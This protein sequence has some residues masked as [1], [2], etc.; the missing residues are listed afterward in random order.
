MLYLYP[1]LLGAAL[2]SAEPHQLQAV[3]EEM[4]VPHRL[5]LT[6]ELLK[7]ELAVIMLQ[8]KL[9]KEAS[10]YKFIVLIARKSQCTT[11][12]YLNTFQKQPLYLALLQILE[13][14]K[15]NV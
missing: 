15:N 11:V 14:F 4:N 1:F 6:L 12:Y 5:A 9:G 3:L 7:K 10:V 13:K 2:T 8:Q